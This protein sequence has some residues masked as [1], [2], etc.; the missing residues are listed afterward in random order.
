[1]RGPHRKRI[2]ALAKIALP[3]TATPGN[4]FLPDSSPTEKEHALLEIRTE[5]A[6]GDGNPFALRP[7]RHQHLTNIYIYSD[8]NSIVPTRIRSN[9]PRWNSRRV[10]P[11][12]SP[13]TRVPAKKAKAPARRTKAS[14]HSYINKGTNLSKLRPFLKPLPSRNPTRHARRPFV[15]CEWLQHKQNIVVN[16][17]GR[18]VITWH[19]LS[20][21]NQPHTSK[22]M[23]TIRWTVDNRLRINYWYYCQLQKTENNKKVPY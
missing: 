1:M 13:R 21:L 19:Y 12:H 17:Q 23:D 20:N 18:Q 9:V 7:V 16:E 4:P 8:G 11:A 10:T 2:V 22:I 5:S 14:S 15:V 3:I 6:Y